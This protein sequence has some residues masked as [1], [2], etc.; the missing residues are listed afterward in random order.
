MAKSFCNYFLRYSVKSVIKNQKKWDIFCKIVDNF[1]DIGVCWRLAKQLQSDYGFEIRF[2][3][4]KPIVAKQLLTDIDVSKSIQVYQDVTIVHWHDDTPFNDAADVVLET[5]ACGLPIA[6]LTNMRAE[7]IWVNVDHLSAESWVADFHAHHGKHRES[8]LTRHFYFPGFDESTGGLLRERDLI[9]QRDVFQQSQAVQQTF[10]QSLRINIASDEIKMSL[11]SY[12]NAPI[13]EL[14]QLLINGK[15]RA[16][17][18]MPLN[19]CLPKQLLGQKNIA[20]GDCFNQGQLTLHILPFLSQDYYDKLLWACD[21]NIVRGEDSW[22]RAIWA[23]KPF[24]W[25]PY[26]QTEQT[27]LLKLNAFLETF[28]ANRSLSEVISALNQDWAEGNLSADAWSFYFARLDGIK[29]LTQSQSCALIQQ[30][31]LVPKLVAFCA[32]LIK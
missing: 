21:I 2:F 18:F 13:D 1:G 25:Q 6:Y 28:Y 31:T 20:I 10:W 8:N 24:I 12:P 22:V 32:N 11:F 15:R 23:G 5:F 19:D 27:H 3:V 9:A 7:S 29:A 26:W 16:S 4:D 17:L 30:K 14:L